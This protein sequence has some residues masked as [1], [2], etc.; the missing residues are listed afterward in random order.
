MRARPPIK[1]ISL[2]PLVK[3]MVEAWTTL[4]RAPGGGDR[5]GGLRS[6]RGDDLA[7]TLRGLEAGPRPARLATL[8]WNTA[9]SAATPVAIP[10]W[11]K[12]VLMPEPIPACAGGTTP[13]AVE[14]IPGLVSPIPTPA[15]RKPGEQRGPA[16]SPAP[17]PRISSRPTPTVASRRRAAPGPGS[18]RR[19]LPGDRRHE[20]REQRERQEAQA[21]LQRRV[22]EHALDVEREVE[23]HREHPGREAEG[24]DRDPV[25]G[26]LAEQAEVEHRVVAAQLDRD[27]R[28]QQ[29]PRRRSARR[30]SAAL[31][32]ALGVAADQAEDQQRR[33]T[34]EKVTRPAQSIRSGSW[35]A[36]LA[37]LR[38]ASAIARSRSGR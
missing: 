7:E 13:I 38:S 5:R 23:E 32:P 29:R 12:V 3:A 34:S 20:E 14:P 31:A 17:T 4:G 24:D 1:R 16:P 6:A 26:G 22:A 10:T 15:T 18:A 19:E 9:P 2:S 25:E 30:G 36:T 37:S 11:R 21:G 33:A 35:A 28:G 27:E 8:D